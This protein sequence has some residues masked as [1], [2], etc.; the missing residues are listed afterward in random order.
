MTRRLV[1]GCLVAGAMMV[2]LAGPALAGG[3]ATTTLDEVPAELESG[4]T[5]SIGYTILQHG[6]S[7]A[8]VE[9]TMIQ[10]G[11]AHV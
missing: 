7:P 6:K 11:R 3:W 5:Y 1:V 8:V 10:I 4:E 9:D 2:A